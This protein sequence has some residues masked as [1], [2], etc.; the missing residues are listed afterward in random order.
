M[1]SHRGTPPPQDGKFDGEGI[2]TWGIEGIRIG[3]S[4]RFGR[5]RGELLKATVLNDASVGVEV[6]AYSG[7]FFKMQ[8]NRSPVQRSMG[9]SNSGC[10][11]G[12]CAH[13]HS[14]L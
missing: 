6:E 8:P 4:G 11:Q 10:K 1:G 2:K 9:L 13:S 5:G 12:S 7:A 3:T 14:H